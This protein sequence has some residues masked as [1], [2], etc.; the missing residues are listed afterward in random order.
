MLCIL[1]DEE[2]M[3]G[4]IPAL[5][6]G[7]GLEQSAAFESSPEALKE[8]TSLDATRSAQIDYLR[9]HVCSCMC[10]RMVV[11]ME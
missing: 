2:M 10:S 7:L 11:V 6:D 9:P 4:G 5:L 3:A 1:Y 8:L